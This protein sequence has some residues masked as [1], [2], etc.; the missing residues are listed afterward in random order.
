MT[1][2]PTS[3]RTNAFLMQKQVRESIL[4]IV[5]RVCIVASKSQKSTVQKRLV[6]NELW[7]IR[8]RQVHLYRK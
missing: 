6:A 4:C 7:W 5:T 2:V 3:F 8:A 1:V